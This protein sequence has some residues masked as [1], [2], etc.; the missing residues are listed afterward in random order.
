LL[1]GDYDEPY[2][3]TPHRLGNRIRVKDRPSASFPLPPVRIARC[4]ESMLL[5]RLVWAECSNAKESCAHIGS[6]VREAGYLIEQVPSDD[7]LL[8]L[9]VVRLDVDGTAA[10]SATARMPSFSSR[11]K[12]DRTAPNASARSR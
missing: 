3:I 1:H 11:L 12:Y 6:Q 2:P 5:K 4:R 9:I 10:R 7:V 8:G